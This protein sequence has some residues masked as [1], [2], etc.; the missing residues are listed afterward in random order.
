[1]EPLQCDAAILLSPAQFEAFAMPGLRRLAEN[2]DYPIY[3]LDGKATMRFMDHLCGL[4]GLKAIQYNP[5]PAVGYPYA[6]LDDFQE[7]RRRGLALHVGCANVK[8]AV[9]VTKALGPDGLF[10]YLPRFDSLSE[11]EA[12]Q[13]AIARVC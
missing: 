3:H 7:I 11:A 10:I 13:N 4:P 9:A 6:C 5:E 2:V 1:M 8:D 12:A